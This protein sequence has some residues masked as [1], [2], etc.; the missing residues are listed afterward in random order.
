MI[1]I[2]YRKSLIDNIESA[3]FWENGG[4]ISIEEFLKYFRQSYKDGEEIKV[5]YGGV[6]NEEAI[7]FKR[8]LEKRFNPN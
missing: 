3:R 5:L 7:E 8:K 4:L 6:T 1:Y 2:E